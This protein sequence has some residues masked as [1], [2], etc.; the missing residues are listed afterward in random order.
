MKL[1]GW[2]C[3][4]FG[5]SPQLLNDAQVKWYQPVAWIFAYRIKTWHE[6]AR[7]GLRQP[8]TGQRNEVAGLENSSK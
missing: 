7:L 1:A 2:R 5:T 4:L 3:I 8:V 6:L